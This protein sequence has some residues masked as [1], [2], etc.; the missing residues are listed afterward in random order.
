VAVRSLHRSDRGS[1]AFEPDETVHR[2]AF[3]GGLALKLKTE[4]GEERLDRL[5]VVHDEE[6]VVHPQNGHR[7][8]TGCVASTSVDVLER[9]DREALRE[10]DARR[11]DGAVAVRHLVEVLLVVV[12]GVVE[13]PAGRISVLIS[14]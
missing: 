12:L 9:L 14:P 3:D 7:G 5:E 1:D 4:L 8:R 13:R 11:V 10:L 2:W 6:D